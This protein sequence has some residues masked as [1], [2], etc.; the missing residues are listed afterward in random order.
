MHYHNINLWAVIFSVGASFLI[1][2]L[3]YSPFLFGQ[4]WVKGLRKSDDE[5]SKGKGIIPFL[6]ALIGAFAISLLMA[7]FLNILHDT[8]K[9]HPENN[10][11]EAFFKIA[12]YI[13]FAMIGLI[14]ANFERSSYKVWLVNAAFR[15]VEIV[16]ISMILFFFR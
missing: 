13:W 2:S 10:S 14:Q 9:D 11:P 6:T 5:L 12:A 7:H 1:S 16:T 8:Y 4:I 15:F 3:W